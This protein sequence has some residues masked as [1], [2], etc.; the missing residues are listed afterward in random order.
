MIRPPIVMSVPLVLRNLDP[1]AAKPGGFFSSLLG[2]GHAS[3][4]LGALSWVGA[5]GT[6]LERSS[7]FACGG[8]GHHHLFSVHH[9]NLQLGVSGTSRFLQL[10]FWVE[11]QTVSLALCQRV[12]HAL[13]Q[14]IQQG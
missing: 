13:S 12:L 14:H 1:R 7:F 9:K 10:S 11:L 2:F 4:H 5:L 6:W 3:A 8:L